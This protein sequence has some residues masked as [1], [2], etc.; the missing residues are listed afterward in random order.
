M[1]QLTI[2][3]L[4]DHPPKEIRCGPWTVDCGPW[5]VDRLRE[6]VFHIFPAEGFHE[7]G[8]VGNEFLGQQ[9]FSFL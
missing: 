1:T 2:H 7:G 5:T 9:A 8:V 6:Q 4:N 3:E